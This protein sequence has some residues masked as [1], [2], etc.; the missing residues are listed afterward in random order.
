[1]RVERWIAAPPERVY[2]ALLDAAAVAAWR[3][4]EGMTSEVHA[5]EPRVG[6]RVRVSLSYDDPARVGKSSRRTDT[7]AGRFTELVPN[8]RV[9]EVDEFE[10]DD[11]ALQGAM[12]MAFELTPERG[13]TRVTGSHDGL[14][15]GLSEE[16]NREGWRS[17]LDRLAAL[18]DE[19]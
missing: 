15:P 3:V 7:Y 18:L 16:D 6:G 2:E 8:R 17:A 11:P 13:G 5:F 4:P 9:V 1:V 14:P 19:A 10:T 12:T